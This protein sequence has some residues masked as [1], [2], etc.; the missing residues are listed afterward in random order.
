MP[1]NHFQCRHWSSRTVPVI[2]LQTDL[3]RT[4]QGS[5]TRALKMLVASSL[6]SGSSLPRMIAAMLL[7]APG[8]SASCCSLPG[9]FPSSIAMPMS[10]L[11]SVSG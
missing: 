9:L 6:L 2:L 5:L 4:Q 1:G 7:T 8:A 3:K 10:A 11:T